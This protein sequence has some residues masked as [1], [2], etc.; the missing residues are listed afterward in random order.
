MIDLCSQIICIRY[1][2]SSSKWASPVV[3]VPKP[4]GSIRV[5]GDYKAI[6]KRI[7]DD[8]YKLPNVLNVF[9]MLSQNG[10]NPVLS[11]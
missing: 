10:T 4:D 7:E 8:M 9:A 2:V 11:Q 1:P 3:H 5:C 6:N